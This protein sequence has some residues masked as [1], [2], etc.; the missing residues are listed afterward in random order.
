[1]WFCKGRRTKFFPVKGKSVS[2]YKH[3]PHAYPQGDVKRSIIFYV[4]I[5]VFKY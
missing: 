3:F 1:M 5:I 4:P 2:E